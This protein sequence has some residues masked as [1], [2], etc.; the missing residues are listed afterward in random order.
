MASIDTNSGNWRHL[1]IDMQRMFSEETPWQ[2]DWMPKI[3]GNVGRLV[4]EWPE[5]TIFTRFVPPANAKAAPG[6]WQSYYRKW[7]M[8]T[9]DHM[10]R[11][12][13]E[14]IPEL[15]AFMPPAVDFS[16]YTYSPWTDGRLHHDLHKRGVDTV[17][18]SGGETDV[19]VL[20]AVL[21]AIDL[22]YRVFLI[23]DAVCSGRDETH[24]ASLALL[25]G[26]FAAQLTLVKTGEMIESLNE[27]LAHP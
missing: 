20:A 5:Q 21:G 27:I 19:C 18:I 14:V 10:R 17:V 4:Q 16:K 25:R 11:E 22:G 24:D 12:L 6:Q 1:C 7:W 9:G 15:A 2:V 23:E 3:L 26:R 13:T 8:M